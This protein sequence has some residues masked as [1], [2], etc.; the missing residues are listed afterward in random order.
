MTENFVTK[1]FF[2]TRAHILNKAI[3]EKEA[4]FHR[5]CYKNNRWLASFNDYWLAS[6]DTYRLALKNMKVQH[7][8]ERIYLVTEERQVYSLIE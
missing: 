5:I 2:K 7:S 6:I 3:T 8:F 1:S 4:G